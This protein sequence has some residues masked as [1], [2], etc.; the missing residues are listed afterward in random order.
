MFSGRWLAGAGLGVLLGTALQLQERSLGPIAAYAA[1]VLL[2]AGLLLG[3]ARA[4]V[5]SRLFLWTLLAATALSWGLTGWRAHDR[6][7]DVLPAELDGRDI[8]ITGVVANLPVH[9]AEGAHFRFD[10]EAAQRE[11]RPV[12]T[13]QHV[14]LGWYCSVG[15]RRVEVGMESWSVRVGQ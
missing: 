8:E 10:V 11:G 15:G 13:P 3:L 12:Q 1:A 14:S 5:L 7:A 6:L 9:T 2:G 4:R